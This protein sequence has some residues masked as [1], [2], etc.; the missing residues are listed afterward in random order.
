M[1]G[2]FGSSG[3]GRVLELGFSGFFAVMLN[4]RSFGTVTSLY[5]HLQW[6][7][8]S[9]EL[10][11]HHAIVWPLSP[12]SAQINVC[13]LASSPWRAKAEGGFNFI[14][15]KMNLANRQHACL[16][17]SSRFTNEEALLPVGSKRSRHCELRIRSESIIACFLL[18]NARGISERDWDKPRKA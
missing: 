10:I 9:F 5:Q 16:I 8:S 1:L 3:W 4:P 6:N 11:K 18:D 14:R 2:Q 17:L 12:S 15:I 13:S 7:C